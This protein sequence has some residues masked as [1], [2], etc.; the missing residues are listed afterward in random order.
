MLNLFYFNLRHTFISEFYA[1]S[2][3]IYYMQTLVYAYIIVTKWNQISICRIWRTAYLINT[4]IYS[5]IKIH[6]GKTVFFH[7]DL[8]VLSKAVAIINKSL[9]FADNRSG[10]KLKI[11]LSLDFDED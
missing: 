11:F 4:R 3:T 10:I 6:C 2:A 1:K 5:H 8:C 9:K 7:W